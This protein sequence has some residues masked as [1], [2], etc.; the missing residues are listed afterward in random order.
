VQTE[1]L[2]GLFRDHA[3]DV[4]AYAARRTDAA[5][6]EEVV[7]EVFAIA[8]R[9]LDRVPSD[10]PLLWLYAV[11]RRVLANQQRAARR[12][13]R[14]SGVLAELTRGRAGPA[15]EGDG[16]VR[17]ALAALSEADREVLMLVAWEGLAA[18]EAAVVLGCSAQAVHTRLHR[19][20][21]RLEA[22]LDRRRAAGSFRPAEVNAR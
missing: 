6:A 9:R 14:L 2:E 22:E 18:P 10:E 19:A 4:L 11:A 15:T 8:W 21:R 5:T 20:R 1:R 12:R 3:R 7:A 17:D 13:A 16:G